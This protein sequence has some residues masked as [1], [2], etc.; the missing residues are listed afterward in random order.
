MENTALV[1]VPQ[2]LYGMIDK[3]KSYTSI[4]FRRFLRYAEIIEAGE[5]TEQFS[6]CAADIFKWIPN[7]VRSW[8]LLR[9]KQRRVL[10]EEKLLIITGSR[11]ER[12]CYSPLQVT[13]PVTATS[14]S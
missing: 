5:A 14:L 10:R 1:V 3:T 13:C 4:Y 2:I 11:S 8:S 9:L 7:R 6:L 12:P